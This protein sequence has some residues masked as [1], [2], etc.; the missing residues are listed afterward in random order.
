MPGLP[1]SGKM[2]VQTFAASYTAGAGGTTPGGGGRRLLEAGPGRS[3]LQ[4]NTATN[5]SAIVVAGLNAVCSTNTGRKLLQKFG[6]EPTTGGPG[7]EIIYACAP[8]LRVLIAPVFSARH[9]YAVAELWSSWTS[10]YGCACKLCTGK[11]H[12]QNPSQLA[13][14]GQS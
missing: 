5:E 9:E 11:M 13:C 4:S 14:A 2:Y 8:R 10:I 6:G 12:Y 3:L 7:L 1:V